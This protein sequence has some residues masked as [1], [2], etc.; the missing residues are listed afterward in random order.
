MEIILHQTTL[1]KN[2]F[3]QLD[4]ETLQTWQNISKKKSH[5]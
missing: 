5:M 1:N 2:Y 4:A 3:L